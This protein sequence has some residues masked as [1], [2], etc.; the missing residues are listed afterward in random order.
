MEETG[1]EQ[2]QKAWGKVVAKAWSDELFKKRL[3]AD[4][5]TV[6]KENGIEIPADMTFKVLEDSTKVIHLILP[7]KP[8]ELSDEEL[9]QV[10]GGLIIQGTTAGKFLSLGITTGTTSHKIE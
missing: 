8:S 1:M 3:L 4:P 9:E 10:A 2:F 6:L 5:K 7:T